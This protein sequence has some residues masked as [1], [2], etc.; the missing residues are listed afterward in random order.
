MSGKEILAL[1][2]GENDAKA[3]TVRDYLLALLRRVWS[4]Q[5]GFSGKR[6]FR[7]S[8]WHLDLHAALIR[9]EVIAGAIDGDGYVSESDDKQ[10]DAAIRSAIDAL[11]G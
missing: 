6:P 1:P 9:A 7:N 11:G 4:E 8:G 3:A 5:E 2:M 10:A